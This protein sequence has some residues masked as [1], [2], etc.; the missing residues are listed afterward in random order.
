MK[1]QFNYTTEEKILVREFKASFVDSFD[2]HF[3]Y[4][5]TPNGNFSEHGN[6]LFTHFVKALRN[7]K[8]LGT[9]IIADNVELN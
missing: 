7:G 9:V 4:G 1:P 5:F 8:N 2:I 3:V 6:T